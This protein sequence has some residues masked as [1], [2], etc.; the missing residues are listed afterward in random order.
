MTV[1]LEIT[2]DWLGSKPEPD[3][4]IDTKGTGLRR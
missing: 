3:E 2:Q 4:Y 1:K